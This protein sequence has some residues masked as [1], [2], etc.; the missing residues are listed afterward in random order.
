MRTNKILL[1]YARQTRHMLRVADGAGMMLFYL[2]RVMNNDP[3]GCTLIKL[4]SK[5]KYYKNKNASICLLGFHS[6]RDA[7]LLN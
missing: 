6:V 7:L 5:R 4:F 1:F 2:R 3:M